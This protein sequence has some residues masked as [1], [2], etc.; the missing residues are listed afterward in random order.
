MK[1]Q[2][3]PA[4]ETIG[5]AKLPMRSRP[6]ANT[7]GLGRVLDQ[8][9]D[10][11]EVLGL[12]DIDSAAI[13]TGLALR[14]ARRATGLTQAE[15]AKLTGITQ[16]AIS[17]IERGAGKDGPSARVVRQIAAAIGSEW[18]LRP[19]GEAVASAWDET[20]EFGDLVK[21][22]TGKNKLDFVGV[23]GTLA[24]CWPIVKSVL[25]AA[26]YA[27]MVQAVAELA[28]RPSLQDFTPE[29]LCG[30]WKLQPHG[31]SRLSVRAP[32]LALAFHGHGKVA[33]PNQPR[34]TH[35]DQVVIAESDQTIELR[36]DGGEALSVMTM[37][38]TPS[39]ECLEGV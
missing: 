29:P 10:R 39:A 38:I 1:N 9:R 7:V 17:N 8:L 6:P 35:Y 13:E 34:T 22:T 27:E 26:A 4:R 36:N 11:P 15:V 3:R 31:R 25:P 18:V 14:R 19:I 32:V 28:K 2:K 16:G 23:G 33:V 21:V 5:R 20:V 24:L 12:E 37:L 30:F